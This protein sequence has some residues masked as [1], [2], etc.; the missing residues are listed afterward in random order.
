[1]LETQLGQFSSSAR[2]LGLRLLTSALDANAVMPSALLVQAVTNCLYD[3]KITVNKLALD[4]LKQRLT[5]PAPFASEIDSSIA[6]SQDHVNCTSI[7]VGISGASEPA[8]ASIDSVNLESCIERLDK[9]TDF[10]LREEGNSSTIKGEGKEENEL[11]LEE[12]REELYDPFYL[13]I[14][15]EPTR[16][17]TILTEPETESVASTRNWIS[18]LKTMESFDEYSVRAVM[19]KLNSGHHWSV[20]R[21][22]VEYLL[23]GLKVAPPPPKPTDLSSESISSAEATDLPMPPAASTSELQDAEAENAVLVGW[24]NEA[25]VARTALECLKSE[26]YGVRMTAASML[27]ALL[28]SG[29]GTREVILSGDTLANLLADGTTRQLCFKAFAS[30]PQMLERCRQAHCKDASV[31]VRRFATESIRAVDLHAPMSIALDTLLE[32]SRDKDISVRDSA[33]HWWKTQD[34][35][36][37]SET[38]R[39]TTAHRLLRHATHIR[40]LSTSRAVAVRAL[41]PVVGRGHSGATK[42]LISLL[43]DTEVDVRIAA[44]DSLVEVANATEDVVGALIEIIDRPLRLWLRRDNALMEVKATAFWVLAHI[45]PQFTNIPDDTRLGGN[46]RVI[47]FLWGNALIERDHVEKQNLNAWLRQ[48][49]AAGD[50]MM[51]KVRRAIRE[52]RWEDAR[53]DANIAMGEYLIAKSKGSHPEI[54]DRILMM[55]HV[56][57]DI[58]NFRGRTVEKAIDAE[59]QR[60]HN[61]WKPEINA[62]DR[63]GWTRLHYLTRWEMQVIVAHEMMHLA[64][65]WFAASVY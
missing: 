23:H 62:V 36:Q 3:E 28:P 48:T 50:S 64:R 7:F 19:A 56:F 25:D 16:L 29:H 11:G 37:C 13:L 22:A 34:F 55:D 9:E 24:E 10:G 51:I 47:D 60:I 15:G 31:S 52:G 17:S 54:F 8:A 53:H 14:E 12:V 30:D 40:E 44:A 46:K 35:S 45:E 58:S 59:L 41:V 18:M 6:L 33:L 42:N 5:A 39:N 49:L 32:C 65:S 63:E 57:S 21:A 38:W 61:S 27:G 4:L 2:E 43:E 26:D 20:R 1:V